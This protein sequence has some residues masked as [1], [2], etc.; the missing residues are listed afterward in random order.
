METHLLAIT[1]KVKTW[2]LKTKKCGKNNEAQIPKQV[3]ANAASKKLSTIQSCDHCHHCELTI[4][5]VNNQYLEKKCLN[6][7]NLN[8]IYRQRKVGVFIHLMLIKFKVQDF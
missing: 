5:C 8:Y 3:S 1:I 6:Y 7:L 4:S 2:T